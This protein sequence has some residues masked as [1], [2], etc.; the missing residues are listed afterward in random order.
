MSMNGTQKKKMN[1]KAS[2]HWSG[3]T[4]KDFTFELETR[5]SRTRLKEKRNEQKRKVHAHRTES[6]HRAYA[7]EILAKEM[8][9][10]LYVS[11]RLLSLPSETGKW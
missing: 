2:Q 11:L 5:S 1:R 8:L 3:Q 6:N 10:R 9:K 7:H 4:G